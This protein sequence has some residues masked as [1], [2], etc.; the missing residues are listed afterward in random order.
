MV[1]SPSHFF[2]SFRLM[3]VTVHL[4]QIQNYQLRLSQP[5]LVPSLIGQFYFVFLANQTIIH[6]Y[7][8]MVLLCL[9]LKLFYPNNYGFLK[10]IA[11]KVLLIDTLKD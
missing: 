9:L 3:R 10:N 5:K 4:D 2:S 6:D 1:K 8:I 11:I 7:P